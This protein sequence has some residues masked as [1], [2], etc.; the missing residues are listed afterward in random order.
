MMKK[1]FYITCIINSIVLLPCPGA[2]PSQSV[3]ADLTQ[4]MQNSIVYLQISTGGYS[5]S[6]PWQ[7]S[8][9]TDSWA[10][11]CAVGQYEVITT[12]DKV[13]NLAFMR[14]LRFGQNKFVSAQLTVVD[15]QTNLCLIRLDPNELGKPLV[16]LKFNEDYQK[17]SEVS[18]YWLSSDNIL[19]NARGFFDR[20]NM[21]Q[22]QTS[23]EQYLQYI[24]TN[25]SKRAGSGE[26]FCKGS[27]PIGI[28]CWSNSSNEVGLIPADVIN[29]FL[30]SANNGKYEGLGNVG[31]S[32][33]ELLDPAMRNFLKMPESLE[34]GVYVSDVFTLGTG[35]DSLKQG[36]VILGIDGSSLDPYGRFQHPKYGLISFEYLITGKRTGEDIKFEIWRNGEKTEINTK[37]KN[38]DASEM[39]VPYQ[40]YDRQPQYLITGGFLFQKL[41]REYLMEFGANI[42]GDAPS[43][44][45][46]YYREM[47]FKPTAERKDIIVL[48]FA[49][50]MQYNVGYTGLGQMVVSTFNGRKISSIKD[51]LEAQ[52]LNPESPYD[53]IEFEMDAPMLIISRKQIP[54]AAAFAITTYGITKLSNITE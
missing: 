40:E 2:S 17:G 50:P 45:Y 7:S 27:A 31:F 36:D 15:Y 21:Q 52:K 28:A 38:F 46:Y 39:L 51:I 5:Q 23:F 3:Q 32:I 42:A 13:A 24:I 47:A 26:I 37:V 18:C 35:S 33:S 19:Y 30:N 6:E 53:V 44:L 41:T 22:S 11:A 25:S 16:P 48:S 14:A 54:A 29:K 20:V 1:V 34:N 43:E 4:A 49:L 12:A 10:C 9:P 8:S